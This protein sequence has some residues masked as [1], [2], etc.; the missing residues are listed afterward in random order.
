MTAMLAVAALR[1]AIALRQPKGTL[2][3]HSDRA[4]QF[5]ARVFRA[6]LG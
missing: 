1:Q 2:V 6:V 4:G 3:V 5:H